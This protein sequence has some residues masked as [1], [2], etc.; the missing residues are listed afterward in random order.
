MSKTS[1]AIQIVIFT[2]MVVGAFFFSFE[3]GTPK[4]VLIAT[5]DH[6]IDY[7][8]TQGLVKIKEIIERETGG[9]IRVLVRP[10]AQ[11]GSEKETIELTQM[12]IIDIN[13]VSCSPMAEFAPEYAV[14]SLPYMFRDYAHQWA[15]LDGPIGQRMLAKLEPRRLIGLTYYDSGARSFYNKLKKIE[16]PAD[17]KGLKIRV[18]KNEVMIDLVKALGGSPDPIAFEEVY[19]AIQTGRIDGAENNYPSYYT[20]SHFEVAKEYT[21]DAHSRIPEIV[22]FSK[23]TW[24][25]LD[26]ETQNIIRAAAKTSEAHQKKLWKD[27]VREAEKAVRAAGCKIYD[28]TPE[29]KK[30]FEQKVQPLYKKYGADFGDLIQEIKNAP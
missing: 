9:R 12:G 4:N 16:T 27:M 28:P 11:L 22:L 8:T 6:A 15:V 25:A 26:D 7:P 3:R 24:D 1:N 19:S 13:R 23:K 14:F 20:T 29:Q 30:L 5:D 10:S 18:Q 17:L 2:L 21:L